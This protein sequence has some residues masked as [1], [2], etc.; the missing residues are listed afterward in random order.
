MLVVVVQDQ[1]GGDFEEVFLSSPTAHSLFKDIAET[2][3]RSV[4]EIDKVIK[5][6]NQSLVKRDEQVERLTVNERLRVHW[7]SN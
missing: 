5:L 2:F 1:E 4:E 3:N 7:K 6:A